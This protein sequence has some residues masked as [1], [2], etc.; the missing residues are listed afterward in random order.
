MTGVF[1]VRDVTKRFGGLTA[2]DRASIDVGRGEIV[3]LIGPNGAGKSTLF[4][5]IA[6]V[7]PADGGTVGVDGTVLSG[8]RPHRLARLGIARTFQT[9]RPFAALTVR[10]N[11]LVAALTVERRERDAERWAWECLHRVGLA[12][13]AGTTASALPLGMR[14]RLEVARALAIRPTL[15]LL[16]EVLGGL[17]PQE[18]E[19]MVAL[20]REL[21]DE[22]YAICMVEH[23]MAVIMAL[24]DRIYVLHHGAVIASGTPAEVSRDPA[25]IDAYLGE[26]V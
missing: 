18:T 16:D 15:L 11:V 19:A 20:L 12:E 26:T 24:C 13:L 21:R 9:P 3:G 14:K 17:N 25:V 2:V 4:G 22:R 7:H 1:S 5:V 23:V 10:E 8:R 6:G